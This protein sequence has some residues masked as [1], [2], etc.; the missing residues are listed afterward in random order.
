M[1]EIATYF[2]LEIFSKESFKSLSAAFNIHFYQPDKVNVVF[3]IKP[4][5][6]MALTAVPSQ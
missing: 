2:T 4:S 1:A 3:F 6:V 5:I